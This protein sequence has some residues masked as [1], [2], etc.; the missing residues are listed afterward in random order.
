VAWSIRISKRRLLS[1]CAAKRRLSCGG[2]SASHS[3]S[4]ICSKRMVCS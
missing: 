4:I 3:Y 1:G 2:G